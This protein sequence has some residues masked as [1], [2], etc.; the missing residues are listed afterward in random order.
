MS[1]V[2][3]SFIQEFMNQLV[4]DSFESVGIGKQQVTEDHRDVLH[5]LLAEHA[6]LQQ[7]P[8][9]KRYDLIENAIKNYVI[10]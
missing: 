4:A 2:E 1:D 3:K 7:I 6:E 9:D 5:T 8:L 10:S